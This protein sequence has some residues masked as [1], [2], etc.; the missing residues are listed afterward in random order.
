MLFVLFCC[1]SS[2]YLMF[3]CYCSCFDCSLVSVFCCGRFNCYL[4]GE[5]R[6]IFPVTFSSYP[7]VTSTYWIPLV[8]RHPAHNY[9]F[10]TCVTSHPLQITL[11][12]FTSFPTPFPFTYFKERLWGTMGILRITST[13]SLPP[14]THQFSSP[15][16]HTPCSNHEDRLH[17]YI[18][19]F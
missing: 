14:T 5:L 6:Q 18:S 10:F 12:S 7:E 19:I 2:L 11:Y 4:V 16:P 3:V 15:T 13:S 8:L 9:P 1:L 17:S